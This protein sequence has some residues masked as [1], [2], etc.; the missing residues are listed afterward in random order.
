M[1]VDD[2]RGRNRLALFL[3]VVLTA[4]TAFYLFADKVSIYIN[5]MEIDIQA[6]KV[7]AAK[8]LGD[9]KDRRAIWPLANTFTS[10][11]EPAVWE[12]SMKALLKIGSVC[13]DGSPR[14]TRCPDREK[15]K[16]VTPNAIM[17]VNSLKYYY[18]EIKDNRYRER[19]SFYITLGLKEKSVDVRILAAQL[20][21]YFGNEND[22]E[23]LTK[24]LKDEDPRV[25]NAAKISLD[26]INGRIAK[27]TPK[28]PGDV[29]TPEKPS[30]PMP[31]PEE[32]GLPPKRLHPITPESGSPP[33]LSPSKTFSDLENEFKDLGISLTPPF[34]FAA[35]IKDLKS[36]DPS[37][38]GKAAMTLAYLKHRYGTIYVLP[39]LKDPEESVRMRAE[40][41]LGELNSFA[42]VK[43]LLAVY[44]TA[45]E[46][47]KVV[48]FYSLLKMND[49]AA[50]RVLSEVSAGEDPD[51][52]KIAAAVLYFGKDRKR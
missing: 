18:E 26:S 32:G 6:V 25:R 8:E 15:S 13:P 34:N 46:E 44:K 12:A 39:L 37:V 31:V 49:P 16:T 20:L 23:L 24:A 3:I 35:I 11:E 29:A 45:G 28:P 1:T 38:R 9:S 30:D 19:L 21:S 33:V 36:E 52:A 14:G 41:S 27:V 17:I 2:N 42:S 40:F 4:F 43:P 47:E 10:S 7:F 22:V 48:I 51:A 50:R 5:M